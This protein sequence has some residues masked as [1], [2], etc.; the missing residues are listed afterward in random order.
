METAFKEATFFIMVIELAYSEVMRLRICSWR[1][2]N[3]TFKLKKKK[4][5]FNIILK[6]KIIVYKEKF[7]A[8]NET[9]F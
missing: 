7:L 9:E 1:I 8:V 5:R 4:I 6:L 3:C 2:V